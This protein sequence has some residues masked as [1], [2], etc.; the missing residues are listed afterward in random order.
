MDGEGDL[1]MVPG[2]PK[3][4]SKL[5]ALEESHKKILEDLRKCNA[6]QYEL[7]N[8]GRDYKAQLPHIEIQVQGKVNLLRVQNLIRTLWKPN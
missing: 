4:Q 2:G 5:E 1:Q 3:I 8:A 7:S 6:P